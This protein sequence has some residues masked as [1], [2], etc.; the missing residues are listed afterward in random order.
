MV[1][2]NW[3]IILEDEKTNGLYK[4][5]ME[6]KKVNRTRRSDR[7]GESSQRGGKMNRKNNKVGMINYWQ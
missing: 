7:N 3:K 1:L 5:I 4:N 6:R 2:E